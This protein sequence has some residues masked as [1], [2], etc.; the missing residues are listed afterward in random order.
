[1]HAWALMGSGYGMAWTEIHQI[2]GRRR[3]ESLRAR[4]SNLVYD[5]CDRGTGLP[6]RR[7]LATLQ[8]QHGI[9]LAEA[10]IEPAFG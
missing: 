8:L 9:A 10:E 5:A 7:P 3:G 2:R 4:R 6:G 1:M